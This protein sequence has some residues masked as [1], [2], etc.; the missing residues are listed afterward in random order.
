MQKIP[1]IYRRQD[2]LSGFRTRDCILRYHQL[3]EYKLFLPSM[4]SVGKDP[5]NSIFDLV[6]SASYYICTCWMLVSSPECRTRSSTT[7]A[8]QC[9]IMIVPYW[10]RWMGRS[11]AGER[12]QNDDSCS[13]MGRA[14]AIC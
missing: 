2:P 3:D 9:S 13:G 14:R 12:S 10:S 5:I 11:I 6:F 8:V 4:N 1:G 7:N